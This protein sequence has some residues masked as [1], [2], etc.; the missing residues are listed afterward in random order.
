MDADK[1]RVLW[2]KLRK[3]KQE[4]YTLTNHT[5]NA[6]IS[7]SKYKG[8]V[9]CAKNYYMELCVLRYLPC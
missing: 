3:L 2:I 6:N 8:G 4:K 1:N 5:A 7:I 9:I